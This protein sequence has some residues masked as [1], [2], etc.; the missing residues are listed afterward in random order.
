[1]IKML[2]ATGDRHINYRA[3]PELIEVSVKLFIFVPLIYKWNGP[4]DT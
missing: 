1:M 4:H 3:K 2:T